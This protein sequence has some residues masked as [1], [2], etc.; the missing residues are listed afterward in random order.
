M[1]FAIWWNNLKLSEIELVGIWKNIVRS[2]NIYFFDCKNNFILND[3]AWFT[4]IWHF[5]TK[6]NVDFSNIKVVWTNLDL[7][8]K[9]KLKYNIKRFKKL[10]LVK[11]DLEVKQKWKEIVFF[12]KYKDHVWIVDYYQDINFYEV[13]DFKKPVRSMGIGMMPSKLTHL[14]L[15]ISTKLEKEKV[16]YDPFVWLW[17][18]MMVANYFWNHAIGSDLN[19]TPC[20]QNWSWFLKSNFANKNL[21]SNIFKQDIFNP[22]KNK[23]LNE[24]TN[25]VSEWFLG[26]IV[27]KFLNEKEAFHMEKKL[28]NI[29]I[30]WIRNLLS[31]PKLENIVITLPA[32]FLRNWKFYTFENVYKILKEDWI[33]IE[34]VDSIYHRKGQ[35]VGRQIAL[36]NKK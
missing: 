15:N 10:D 30:E 6:E 36:I 12:N 27:W 16:V 19:V 25:V 23:I 18:T 20:K 26:P 14:L 3:L 33:D 34:V 1:Y 4:K 9:E 24:V 29:Y 7:T 11:T 32:Y 35:K 21:K 13:I 17:T 28:K 2:K 8:K 22:F 5:E 31:L